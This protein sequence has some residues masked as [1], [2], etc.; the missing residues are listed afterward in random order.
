MGQREDPPERWPWDWERWYPPPGGHTG[1]VPRLVAWGK[2]PSPRLLMSNQE[3]YVSGILCV[4]CRSWIKRN[5]FL[6][7]VVSFPKANMCGGKFALWWRWLGVPTPHQFS[8]SSIGTEPKFIAGQ[9]TPQSKDDSS[10]PPLQLDVALGPSF[11]FW[12]YRNVLW[13]LLRTPLSGS[14]CSLHVF[15][16]SLSFLLAGMRDILAGTGEAT[17]NHEVESGDH[18]WWSYRIEGGEFLRLHALLGPPRV[19]SK[20]GSHW[21]LFLTHSSFRPSIHR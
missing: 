12:G 6:L 1:T 10:K 11:G 8:S 13:Q 9:M 17:L 15:P 7:S 2:P 16:F 18:P 21:R 5:R 19:F 3:G 4:C 14:V 20:P